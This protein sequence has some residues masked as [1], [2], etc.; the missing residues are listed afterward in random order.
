MRFPYAA[1]EGLLDDRA[2]DEP[3]PFLGAWQ[4]V[5][6]AVVIYLFVL[7]L[8]LLFATYKLNG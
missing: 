7:I 4:R 3:P 5:Y 1:L 6:A 8:V 2:N